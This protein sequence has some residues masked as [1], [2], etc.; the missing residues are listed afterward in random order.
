MEVEKWKR[1]FQ[2]MAE[3][4]IQPDR[5]GRYI[6]EN[7]QQGGASRDSS[8]SFVTPVARDIELAKSELKDNKRRTP[9]QGQRVYKR[10][11]PAPI[12]HSKKKKPRV[13]NDVF[14]TTR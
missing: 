14:T 5:N 2:K 13:L 11:R 3:G 4:K 12:A 7:V 6:V 9:D 10:R 1:H 8:I